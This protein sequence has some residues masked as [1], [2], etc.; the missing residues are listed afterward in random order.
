MIY[1]ALDQENDSIINHAK[2]LAESFATL[3]RCLKNKEFDM[4]QFKNLGSISVYS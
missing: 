1:E 3:E 2:N 4:R